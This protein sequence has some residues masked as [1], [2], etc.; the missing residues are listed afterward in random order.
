MWGGGGQTLET[1][2]QKRDRIVINSGGGEGGRRAP[3]LILT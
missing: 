1:V 3:G 2:S